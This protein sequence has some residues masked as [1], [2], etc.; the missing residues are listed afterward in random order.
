MNV[1]VV[2]TG[3]VGLVVGACLAETGHDVLCAD[4]VAEKIQRLKRGELPIFEPGLDPLVKENLAAG[5]L[6]FTTDV[7]EAVRASDVIF[8]AV[9]TPPGEDG[10]AD[11]QHVLEVAETI[12]KAMDG[13]RIVITKST[14]PVGTAARVRAA[15]R[16]HTSH[17][18]HVCSNPEFLKEGAAVE[19]FMKPDRVVL[20][21]DDPAAA[22]VLRTL[23]EPFVRTGHEILF[24]D[25]TS[26]EITKYAANAMLATRISFM[27]TIAQLCD[28]AG[29]DVDQVRLG[30]GSDSRIGPS[31][32]FSGVGYGGSCLP[33]DVKALVRTIADFGLDGSILEAAEA[34]NEAQKRLLLDLVVARFGGDLSGHTFAVWGLA[35]KPNTDDMRDA[36]SLVTIGGLL[37]RGAR[38]V[39]HDPVAMPEAR[40]RLGDLIE[41]RE[42]NYD[43]L[44]GADALVIHTEWHPYRRPAFDRMRK[45]LRQPIIFDGRNLYKRDAVERLGFEYY[46]VG[47]RPVASG[48]GAS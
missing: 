27:N 36:P 34:V 10:S 1:A 45:M 6:A 44:E 17:V 25:V 28:V 20:G 13:E 11:L 38:V 16:E 48:S 29:A 35:F 24:M 30:I 18:V 9:G 15:I 40:R 4:V 8:V 31:F 33:K 2:G 39:A 47:R 32:L 7:E 42:R 14:V 3:Y 19:D 12:G 22:E 5:R 46:S 37:D 23:Y 41:C 43:V 26:A 21:V